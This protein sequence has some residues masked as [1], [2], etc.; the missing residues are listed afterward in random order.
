MQLGAMWDE[1]KWQSVWMH[2]LPVADVTAQI[3]WWKEKKNSRYV[4]VNENSISQL[5][6]SPAGSSRLTELLTAT[7]TINV[8]CLDMTSTG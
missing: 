6:L 2:F 5:F 7:T 1:L 4:A 3:S 8:I